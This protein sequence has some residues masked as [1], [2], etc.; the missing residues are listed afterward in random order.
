MNYFIYG[1]M[2]FLAFGA[3]WEHVD[4]RKAAKNAPKKA[5]NI[6]YRAARANKA[7][8]AFVVRAKPVRRTGV[9]VEPVAVDPIRVDVVSVLR[10]LG[11]SAKQAAAG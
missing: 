10:N 1:M 6:G 2:C 5:P 4:R 7:R 8:A 9:E 3:I 11:W